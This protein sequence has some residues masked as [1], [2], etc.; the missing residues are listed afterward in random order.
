MIN[1]VQDM[2]KTP[3][4]LIVVAGG[5]GTRMGAAVPK[6]FLQ[7][8]GRPILLRT[9]ER[10]VEAVPGIRIITVLPKDHIDT[11]KELC[12]R[13]SFTA[14]QRLVA[15]GITRFHS[16]KNALSEVPAGALVAVHD[17]VRP[18]VSAGL[19]RSMFERMDSCRALIPVTPVTDTLKLLDKAED[20]TL[21]TKSGP[22]PDRSFLYGA[23]T[24]QIFHSE[25]L[26]AAYAQAFDTSFTDDAS[27]VAKA[28][29]PLSWTEG[30]RFNLKITCPE[31]LILAEAILKSS[32]SC[33]P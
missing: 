7:L 29:V 3:K 25:D 10:F 6:Q 19:I 30:E 18:L 23:Q 13:Y 27:V 4:Y 24:P 31:D 14:P 1:F 11:W 5:S 22:S 17:G 12:I 32:Y 20:G 28:G 8:D 21:Q 26:L 15:G 9:L 2:E 16:V 33:N